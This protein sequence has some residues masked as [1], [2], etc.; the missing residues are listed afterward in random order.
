MNTYLFFYP[1]GAYGSTYAQGKGK[2]QKE[3][4]K[5]AFA[6]YAHGIGGEYL[7]SSERKDFI[8][9]AILIAT[10]TPEGEVIVNDKSLLA[11]Y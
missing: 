10:F 11:F 7:S 2:T 6:N 5:D 9:E 8:K 4:L 3:G 1:F